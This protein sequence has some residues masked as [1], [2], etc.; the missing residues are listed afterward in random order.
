M[1]PRKP[2]LFLILFL[3]HQSTSTP[4]PQT[5][6][7]TSLPDAT[8]SAPSATDPSDSTTTSTIPMSTLLPIFITLAVVLLGI[9][10]YLLVRVFILK[11]RRSQKPRRSDSSSTLS[12]MSV[13]HHNHRP[14]GLS[15]ASV[16]PSGLSYNPGDEE[17]F[18]GPRHIV[19]GPKWQDPDR[20]SEFSYRADAIAGG[21][22]TGTLGESYKS[23]GALGK[24][25]ESLSGGGFLNTEE[26][27][28]NGEAGYLPEYE[29][30]KRHYS[31]QEF[32]GEVNPSQREEP[33]PPLPAEGARVI[34]AA[35]EG[36]T[37]SGEGVT[38][39]IAT[40]G[41]ARPI[42]MPPKYDDVN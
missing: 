26:D 19:V 39:Q 12:E 7:T 1:I 11:R 34:E 22:Y 9:G 33:A 21:Y 14:R 10:T 32:T 31:Y 18:A 38:S 8:T 29:R 5:A 27:G 16:A 13:H 23:E 37:K 3:I 24:S 20:R 28:A 4:L 17:D 2:H 30:K 6:S 25:L 36:S 42:S 35:R 41:S 15:S 40:A